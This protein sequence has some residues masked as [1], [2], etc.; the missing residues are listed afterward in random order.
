MKNHVAEK[1]LNMMYREVSRD[2]K[3]DADKRYHDF[4]SKKQ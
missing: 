3:K 4:V 2:D 1:H